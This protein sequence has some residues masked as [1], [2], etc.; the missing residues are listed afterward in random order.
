MTKTLKATAVF[1]EFR[2]ENSSGRIGRELDLVL[3]YKISQNLS[4]T[5]KA[6]FYDGS[7]NADVTKFWLQFDAKY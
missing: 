2:S 5:A 1:H 3:G 4:A 7:T 6:A